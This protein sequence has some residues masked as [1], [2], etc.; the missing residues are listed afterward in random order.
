[1]RADVAVCHRPEDRVGESVEADVGVRMTVE[2][3]VERNGDA[4]EHDPV[5]GPE[6]VDVETLADADVGK[7]R[8]RLRGEALVGRGDVRRRGQL[9][10]AALSSTSTTSSPAHSATAASSVRSSRPVAAA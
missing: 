6:G 3:A 9:D 4:A 8:K 2:P 1:M 5:A 10:V 7:G